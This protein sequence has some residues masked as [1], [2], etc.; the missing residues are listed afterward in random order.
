[1]ITRRNRRGHE[2]YLHEG[3]TKTGKVSYF[4]SRKTDGV[5]AAA[6]PPGFEVY[7]TGD[8]LIVLRK[9]I[10][11]LVTSEEVTVVYAALKENAKARSAYLDARGDA[12]T[13]FMPDIDVEEGAEDIS[14][15]VPS[16]LFNK[17]RLM[18]ILE[19]SQTFSPRMR[20]VL[21]DEKTRE[22][23]AERWCYSSGIDDWVY[24]GNCGPLPKLARQF[25]RHLGKESFFELM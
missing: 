11:C 13:V 9:M 22:F 18:T 21:M 4:F 14:A 15:R 25:C 6:M 12:I 19:R 23:S 20:F 24:I 16:P 8:G 5:L 2:Y 17:A 1:V 10:P 3:K 7:E